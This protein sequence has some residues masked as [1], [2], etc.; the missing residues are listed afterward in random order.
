MWP[1]FPRARYAAYSSEPMTC[2]NTRRFL[3]R[4]KAQQCPRRLGPVLCS[5]CGASNLVAV[6]HHAC[7]LLRQRMLHCFSR[8]TVSG[9]VCCV[10]KRSTCSYCAQQQGEYQQWQLD[11]VPPSAV[12]EQLAIPWTTSPRALARSL[13]QPG[14]A[15]SALAVIAARPLDVRPWSFSDPPQLTVGAPAAL[16]NP[17]AHARCALAGRQE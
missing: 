2:D 11:D 7:M 15:L 4:G 12:L 5:D 14:L 3:F 10:A 9:C 8:Q 16:A 6:G 13:E 1:S 17:P